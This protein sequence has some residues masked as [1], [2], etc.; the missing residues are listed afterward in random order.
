MK[1]IKN[2]K[3]CIVISTYNDDITYRAL[4]STKTTL[5]KRGLNKIDIFEVPGAF[6][7]PGVISRLIKKYD[8]FVAIGCVIKGETNNFDLFCESITK[9]IMNLSINHKKPIGNALITV[10][11][12]KQA[13][14]RILKGDTAARAVVDVLINEPKKA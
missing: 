1:S 12:K 6:E 3:V 2:K 7:I 11:N 9:G 8:G 13:E 14:E 10:F 4:N 5:I